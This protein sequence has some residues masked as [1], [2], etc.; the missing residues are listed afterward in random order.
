[1]WYTDALSQRLEPLFERTCTLSKKKAMYSVGL[2]VEHP[3]RPQWGPGRVVAVAD[4]RLYVFF[5]D[6]LETRAKVILTE[7]V[8]LKE[9][10]SQADEVLDGLPAAKFDGQNWVLPK[11]KRAAG[12]SKKKARDAALAAG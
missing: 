10:E 7:L 1:M 9:C 11:A 2:L 3:Q 12:E 4:D 5:R 8:S 6:D